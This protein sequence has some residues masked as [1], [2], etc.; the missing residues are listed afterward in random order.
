MVEKAFR[1]L[2]CRGW[3]RADV[4]IRAKRS[5]AVPAGNQ[6]LAGHDRATP[7]CPWPPGR[8]A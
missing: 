7:W 2:G 4:M 8:K 5:Q 3:A 6:Y 1:T